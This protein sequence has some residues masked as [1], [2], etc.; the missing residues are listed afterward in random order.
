MVKMQMYSLTV[1]IDLKLSK[2][3]KIKKQNKNCQNNFFNL[4]DVNKFGVRKATLIF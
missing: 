4:V 3:L 1:C 2:K